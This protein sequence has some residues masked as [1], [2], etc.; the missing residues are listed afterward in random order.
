MQMEQRELANVLLLYSKCATPDRA[1]PPLARCPRL[2]VFVRPGFFSDISMVHT[3][4]ENV[5]ESRAK[6]LCHSFGT[7]GEGK[8]IIALREYVG[9]K[10]TMR[11]GGPTKN[12][13]S[14]I[15]NLCIHHGSNDRETKKK[16]LLW[17]HSA[18]LNFVGCHDRIW[19]WAIWEDDSEVNNDNNELF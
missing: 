11:D 2:V 12:K 4:E 9:R 6:N 3:A 15:Y 18:L 14:A 13:P 1:S 16:Q 17:S 10:I 8:G 5:A 19:W 7:E